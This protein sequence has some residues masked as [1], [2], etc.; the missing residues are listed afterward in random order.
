MFL[1]TAASLDKTGACGLS[2]WLYM[3]TCGAKTI[4]NAQQIW[5][6]EFSYVN[7]MHPTRLLYLKTSA[8]LLAV[9]MMTKCFDVNSLLCRLI[10][11]LPRRTLWLAVQ[12][13][14]LVD[15]PTQAYIV[16]YNTSDKTG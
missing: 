15:T 2:R 10:S 6:Q 5:Y 8:F 7:Y 13:T 9:Q 16:T 1:S 4:C 14:R 3:Y 12:V 11:A